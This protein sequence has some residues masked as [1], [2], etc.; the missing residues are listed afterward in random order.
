MSAPVT[1]TSVAGNAAAAFGGQLAILVL[2]LAATAVVVRELGTAV[3]GAWS[4][5]GAFIA[6]AALLDIGL[7]VA[8]VRRIADTE[9]R[10]DRRGSGAALGAAVMVT[11]LTGLA[12][13]LIMWPLAIAATTW[14]DIP[15]DIRAEFIS[16]FRIAGVGA[17]LAVPAAALGAVP[18]AMQQLGRLVRLDVTVAFLTLLAQIIAVMLGAGL[19]GLAWAYAGGRAVAL[20]GR[21]VMA[22]RLLGGA[23]LAVSRDYPLWDSLGRFGSLKVLHQLMSQVVLYLD[24]VLV[25]AFVSLEA[26]AYYT[27]ALELAQRLLMIQTNVAQA[28]YPAACAVAAEPDH[29][30]RLYLGTSRAVS[31]FTFPAAIALAVLA[32]PLLRLWVGAQISVNAA[33]I[34]AIVAIAYAVMALTAIPAATADALDRPGMS[35]RYGLVSMALNVAFVLLLVPRFGAVGAAWAI[36]INVLLPTPFFLRAVTTRLA[37]MNGALFL[38]RAIGEPLVPALVLA[39]VLAGS[40]RLFAGAGRLQLPATLALGIAS[41]LITLRLTRLDEDERAF[42]AAI[43]GGRLMLFFAGRA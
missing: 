15:Y 14:L 2:S 30:R 11:S 20:V 33:P 12:V 41:V 19:T 32:E 3:F 8:L 10:G 36:A 42:I 43:P 22:R 16:A 26:V 6:Y 29:L 13:A 40:W 7:S 18:A 21:W 27:V 9:S 39:A 17:A 5:I 23:G 35:V 24:R 1:G 4:L 25:G 34:L 28:Y 38:R 31:L 37:G